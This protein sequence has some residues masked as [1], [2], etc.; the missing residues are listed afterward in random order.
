MQL[1]DIVDCKRKILT[2]SRG[3]PVSW[4]NY[5]GLFL[6]NRK[7]SPLKMEPAGLPGDYACVAGRDFKPA[8]I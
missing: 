3:D 7:V 8:T 6:E 5:N 4:F 2:Q 1:S